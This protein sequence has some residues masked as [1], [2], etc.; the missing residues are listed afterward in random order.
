[1]KKQEVNYKAF[2]P[3]GFSFIGVGVVLMAAIHPA[4]GTPFIGLGIIWIAIALAKMKE[5]EKK[6]E[7]SSQ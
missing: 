4:L 6:D 7:P 2:L 1:M 3:L 5:A